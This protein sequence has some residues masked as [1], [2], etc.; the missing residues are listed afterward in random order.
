MIV[1][2]INPV[3]NYSHFL[4]DQAPRLALY[5]SAG[6]ALDTVSV[7]G[8]R[9]VPFQREIAERFGA[10]EWIHTDRICTVRA[11]EL[12]ILT[13]CAEPRH[14]AHF[15][16]AWA[17]AAIRGAFGVGPA[18]VGT[19]RRLYVSRA[20]AD[21]RRLVG[22]A[23]CSTDCGPLGFEVVLPGRLPVAAQAAL[24]AQASDV[25]GPHGAGLTNVLFCAPARGF[26]S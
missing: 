26:W 17:R 4:S 24:F 2:D 5:A 7:I 13:T 20:D 16:A 15:G 22:E 23:A 8:P 21:R 14:P 1:S 11:A 9:L 25:V 10:G 12:W 19:G 18:R 3:S 6:V